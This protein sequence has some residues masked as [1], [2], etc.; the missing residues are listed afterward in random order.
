[1]DSLPKE[2]HYW[3][4]SFLQMIPLEEQRNGSP[5]IGDLLIRIAN[6]KTTFCVTSKTEKEL[7]F[8]KQT[9]GFVRLII[10]S[11]FGWKEH[12]LLGWL[13]LV[14]ETGL[15]PPQTY[16]YASMVD[17]TIFVFRLMI[18]EG[19]PATCKIVKCEVK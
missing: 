9:A 12:P 1:M 7:I 4:P 17:S 10:S 15:P 5:L 16:K 19:E 2:V 13:S 11:M 14:E 6:D 8:D 3:S 18:K